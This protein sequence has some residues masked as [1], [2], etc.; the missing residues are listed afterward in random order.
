MLLKE[1]ARGTFTRDFSSI[2]SILW[3][4][5]KDKSSEHHP[6]KVLLVLQYLLREGF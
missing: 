6:Y 4:R 5:L 1:I 3:K 2:M